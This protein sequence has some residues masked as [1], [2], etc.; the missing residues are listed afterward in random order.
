MDS[1]EIAEYYAAERPELQAFLRGFGRFDEALDIGCAAGMF[2]SRLVAEGIVGTCDGIELNYE[3]ARIAERRLRHVWAGS[4]ESV[5]TEIP[6]GNYDL[7]MLAD[8]L[9]HLVDPWAV[10]RLLHDKTNSECK[11]LLSVPNVRH[12]KVTLP[13]LFRGEFRYTDAG[14]MD[15][16]HL[17][18]FTRGSIEETL[19]ECGWSVL[20]RGSN[21]KKRYRRRFVP[22]RLIEPFVAV[23]TMF[24]AKKL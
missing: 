19:K 12:Y 7:I 11:M 4:I 18:F 22:T 10:L 6:W 2:S 15:R 1:R 14:I 9:E 17:H 21:M 3:A 13:L 20:A 23:Q 8:V 16:T 24:L 5:A